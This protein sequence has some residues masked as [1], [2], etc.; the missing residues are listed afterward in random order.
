MAVNNVSTAH[1]KATLMQIIDELFQVFGEEKV[2]ESVLD[3]VKEAAEGALGKKIES[4]C[5]GPD[6]EVP[7]CDI[8]ARYR[9]L[10]EDWVGVVGYRKTLEMV[11]CEINRLGSTADDLCRNGVDIVVFGHSHDTK[12]D[13]DSW[14]VKDRIYAN[15]GYWC[16]FGDK[17]NADDNAHFVET[18]GKSVALFSFKDGEASEV[19]SSEL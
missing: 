15:C 17:E 16:G 13:K 4:I 18:D 5:M 1:M 12:M 14:L 3:A 7:Y 9:N 2:A 11:L 19:T 8:R 6:L 10:F